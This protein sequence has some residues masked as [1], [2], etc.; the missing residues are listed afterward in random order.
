MKIGIIGTRGSGKTTI[1]DLLTGGG[2]SNKSGYALGVATVHDPRVDALSAIYKPK[3]TVYARITVVD[4]AQLGTTKDSEAAKQATSVDALLLVMGAFLRDPLLEL[5]EVSSDLIISDLVLVERA[6]ERLN[7][8][9]DSPPEQIEALE[10]ARALL[11]DGVFMGDRLENLPDGHSFLTTKPVIGALNVPESELTDD[12]A[13]TDLLERCDSLGIPVVRFCA[14]VESDIAMMESAEERQEFM[15]AYGLTESGIERLARTAYERL[16][17]ISFFTVGGDEV[18]AWT[19]RRDCPA[20]KAA[21]TIH[22]DLERG[23]IRAEVVAYDDFMQ[24][25]S[26]KAVREAGLFRLE[27]KEY[28]VK[29][30][31]LITVRFNV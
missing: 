18:R 30:G 20:R 17:L 6:I 15:K 27:S 13:H 4:F 19:V 26:M 2:T 28:P 5:D 11:E 12:D 7:S 24:H 10:Q 8:R 3:K 23:F 25:G 31:D 21:G 29:D 14:P 22:S 1:F 9:R 16:G